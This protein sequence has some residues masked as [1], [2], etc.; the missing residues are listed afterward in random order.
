MTGAAAGV[1]LWNGRQLNAAS[2]IDAVE[3]SRLRLPIVVLCRWVTNKPF[4]EF[5]VGLN[6]RRDR[7]LFF[8]AGVE[9]ARRCGWASMAARKIRLMRV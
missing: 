5:Q 8:G 1:F 7:A 4:L 3:V 9:R 6:P 2:S